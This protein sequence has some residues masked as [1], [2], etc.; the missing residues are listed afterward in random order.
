MYTARGI[1][2][3]AKDAE[4]CTPVFDTCCRSERNGTTNNSCCKVDELHSVPTTPRASIPI[5]T[6]DY[7]IKQSHEW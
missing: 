3:V 1:Q 4:P 6:E 7:V 5:S 2:N